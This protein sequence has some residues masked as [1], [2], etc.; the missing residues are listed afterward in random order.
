L[1]RLFLPASE[2]SFQILS[3]TKDDKFANPLTSTAGPA[4]STAPTSA[5]AA[6]SDKERLRLEILKQKSQKEQ[7]AVA[8]PEVKRHLQE[9]VLQKKR[10]EAAASM[11]NLVKMVPTATAPPSTPIL[12]KTASESNLLKMKTGRRGHGGAAAATPYQRGHQ[13]K[14]PAIPEASDEAGDDAPK[15]TG[16]SPPVELCSPSDLSMRNPTHQHH[17]GYQNTPSP[18]R[19]SEPSSPKGLS[20]APP[21]LSLAEQRRR[22]LGAKGPPLSRHHQRS[23]DEAELANSGVNSKSL[24]NIPSAVSRLAGKESLFKRKSPPPHISCNSS[25][26]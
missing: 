4:V 25:I 13:Q 14:C 24:P 5:A 10:K 16:C 23:L 18:P 1:R 2:P 20:A 21:P 7:S 17:R 6:V 26:R 9:F 15:S 12:R 8:S 3:K 11:S 19:G 22:M